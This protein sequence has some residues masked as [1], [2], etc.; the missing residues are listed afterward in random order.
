[1][2]YF[3]LKTDYLG[4]PIEHVIGRPFFNFTRHVVQL[5]RKWLYLH[6]RIPKRPNITTPNT[7]SCDCCMKLS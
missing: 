6:G 7:T 5:L 4:W 2:S 1:M 3:D